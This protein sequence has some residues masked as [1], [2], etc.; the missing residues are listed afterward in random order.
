M[1]QA[2]AVP[3]L[4]HLGKKVIDSFWSERRA[5]NAPIVNQTG[6]I[7]H[8]VSEA[9]R[10]RVAREF[11]V[12]TYQEYES[13]SGNL[14]IHSTLGELEDAVALVLVI[15][16]TTQQMVLFEADVDMGYEIDLPHGV[17][18]II[19]FLLDPEAEDLFSAEIYAIGFPCAGDIDLS[20][21]GSFSVDDYEDVWEL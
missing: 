15:E 14:Y 9:G 18:S 7:G 6:N 10:T 13:L 19:I 1:W 4:I 17:Y 21:I 5:G 3:V 16:E 2:V 11:T 12:S 20:G 8:T